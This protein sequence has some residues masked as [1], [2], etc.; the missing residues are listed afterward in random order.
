MS[1]V[2][3]EKNLE[4]KTA[5]CAIDGPVA[6]RSRGNGRFRCAVKKAELKRRYVE[7]HPDAVRRGRGG[8]SAHRLTSFDEST[9][10]GECPVCGTVGAV[11]KGRRRKDGTP[12]VMCANR[13]KELW[14]NGLDETPQEWCLTCNR[15]YLDASGGC[16]YCDDPE[17]TDVGFGLRATE[18]LRK[19]AEWVAEAFDGELPHIYNLAESDPYSV[20]GDQVENPA[21]KVIGGGVPAGANPRTFVADWWAQNAHL[22]GVGS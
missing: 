22:V 3:T 7:R 12:G 17:Q 9:M 20:D 4:T 8:R 19:E 11:V 18:D 14:P 21:I 16:R 1:H 2:L 5:I 10:T 13:A 6:I 15:V